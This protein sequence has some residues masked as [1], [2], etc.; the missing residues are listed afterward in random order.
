MEYPVY[1]TYTFLSYLP[2]TDPGG[3]HLNTSAIP[4]KHGKV[5]HRLVTVITQSI[6]ID[7]SL[8]TV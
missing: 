3:T 6:G 8:Q 4:L 5:K 7:R 1:D 2:M